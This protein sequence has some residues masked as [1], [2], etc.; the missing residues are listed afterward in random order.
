METAF[1]WKM[2]RARNYKTSWIKIDN[3]IDR[4]IIKTQAKEKKEKAN[5]W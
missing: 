3:K 2:M 1:Y 4:E 5:H